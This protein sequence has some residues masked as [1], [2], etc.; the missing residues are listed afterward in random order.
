MFQ[1]C[2]IIVFQRVADTYNCPMKTD[3]PLLRSLQFGSMQS[4]QLEDAVT[5]N[6]RTSAERVA[7]KTDFSNEHFDAI[8]LGSVPQKQSGEH[9]LFALKLQSRQR[10]RFTCNCEHTSD[11]SKQGSQYIER[12]LHCL[13]LSRGT[14]P[15]PRSTF[16][17]ITSVRDSHI[18]H[19]S[20]GQ[21][22]RPTRS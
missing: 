11:P 17:V 18:L 1:L 21:P 6:F 9:L 2:K 16:S 12:T 22:G 15:R 4:Y 5:G 19:H 7:R 3:R 10:K 8:E 13:R 14:D 20:K